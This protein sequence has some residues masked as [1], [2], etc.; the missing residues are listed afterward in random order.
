M[1]HAWSKKP[2]EVI[3]MKMKQGLVMVMIAMSAMVVVTQAG[4]AQDSSGADTNCRGKAHKNIERL[5]DE[6]NI[7]AQQKEQ[8]KGIM[9]ESRAKTVANR[10]KLRLNRQ[11]LK[12]EL[13][14][15]T[16]DT[17]KINALVAD[18]KSIEGQLTDERV[19]H[20]LRIKA[21]LTPE[22]F[23]KF[24]EKMA[25]GRK[26]RMEL[27]REKVK[28]YRRSCDNDFEKP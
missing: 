25:N 9:Q 12:E 6:L 23:V 8:L 4:Y 1:G 20:I 5:F 18:V 21:V 2:Q 10:E 15:V 16:S 24:K 11:A 27:M 26:K 7:T 14:K 13:E 3:D 28:Q 17:A 22:Q 19:S